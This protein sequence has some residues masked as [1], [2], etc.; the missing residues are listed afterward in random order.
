MRKNN[1]IL[2]F[3]SFLIIF[4][5]C[6]DIFEEDISNEVINLIL[7]EQGHANEGNVVDFLWNS[8]DGVD[9]YRI[10]IFNENQFLE[11][12]SLIDK[13]KT[14]FTFNL[15]PGEYKWRVKA[16]NFAYETDY[17]FERK[18]NVLLSEELSNQELVLESPSNN[19]YANTSNVI[20]TWKQLLGAKSYTVQVVQNSN[21]LLTLLNRDGITDTF[22]RLDNSILSEDAEY[23]WRVKA[24]NSISE[25]SFFEN[26]LFIDTYPPNQPVLLSPENKSNEG[27]T[28]DFS[29]AIN[30]DTGNI[31]SPLTSEIEIAIDSNFSSILH[32]QNKLINNYQY[33]FNSIG[34]YFW[35]IKT[36]DESLNESTYS[37]V[38]EIILQ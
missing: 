25:T 38:R 16:I 20:L 31:Q 17:S 12:D 34:T 2:L 37:E 13:S 3:F 10:Q 28:V 26:L 21:G 24:V 33:E 14:S 5:S 15:D 18:F 22:F 32:Q 11:L 23:T 36:I 7:P 8:V 19:F 30:G 27:L 29:W 4:H 1:K 6:D 9:N 35:R